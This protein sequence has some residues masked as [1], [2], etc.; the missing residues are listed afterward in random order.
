MFLLF[1]I[2]YINIRL[3]IPKNHKL[4]KMDTEK[5]HKEDIISNYFDLNI[6]ILKFGGIWI[7]DK[8]TPLKNCIS[9]YAYN[10]FWIIYCIFLYQP[11]ESAI[12]F[13]TSDVL[14]AVRSLRDQFNHLSCIFKLIIWF[15]NR[16]IILHVMRS[17]Q[18]K[19]FEYEDFEQFKSNEIYKE[20]EKESR[21]WTK[22]FLFGVNSIC[23]NMCFS[24]LY[25]FIFYY[26]DLYVTDD[27]GTLIYNQELAVDLVL[28]YKITN[29]TIFL[30]TFTFQIVALDIYGFMI[31]GT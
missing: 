28:P 31:I 13:T 25:V 8:A 3:A 11:S 12:M 26:K 7:D 15:T 20:H 19:K 24:I 29:R 14:K 27:D 5:K 1:L 16:R 9:R 4:K 18:S 22:I 2:K 23:L 30:L 17:L 6:S 10:L 21:I